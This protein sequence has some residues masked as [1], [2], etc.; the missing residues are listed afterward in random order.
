M[1]HVHQMLVRFNG[2][3][4]S[5]DSLIEIF[6][7]EFG[8]ALFGSA[9]GTAD[10]RNMA[11]RL[12]FPHGDTQMVH[13]HQEM[14]KVQDDVAKIVYSD[15]QTGMVIPE[16]YLL[17]QSMF[18]KRDRTEAIKKA[19]KLFQMTHRKKKLENEFK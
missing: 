9:K 5:K 6:R 11:I 3:A 7:N 12:G 15:D 2:K 10:V 14:L 8:V 4:P 1:M 19:D 16:N 17:I 18:F 13:I